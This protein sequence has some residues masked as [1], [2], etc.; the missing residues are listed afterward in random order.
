MFDKDAIQALTEAGSIHAAMTTIDVALDKGAE[1]HTRGIATLPN[2]FS[3]H[4][5]EKHLPT[6]RRARG[7]MNSEDLASFAAYTHQHAEA[8]A[9]V[10]VDTGD[11]TATAVLNLGLPTAPGHADN[12]ALL[13]SKPTAAFTAMKAI[14]SNQAKQATVAEWLEDWAPHITCYAGTDKVA[15]GLAVQAVRNLTI[16]SMRQLESTEEQLSS[17][18]SAFEHVKARS[19]NPLPTFI[20]VRCQPYHGFEEREFVL[21]VAVLTGETKPVLTLRVIKM[22][23]HTQQ[24]AQEL[25][26]RVRDAINTGATAPMPVLVGAYRTQA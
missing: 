12:K 9:S 24:M 1:I 10:F 21:R 2:D 4:D 22:E 17:T 6:R 25:A 11:M 18:V 8:G 16:E 15:N 26:N 14:A 13:T 20:Y 7:L 23:E 19:K 3:V 5:L